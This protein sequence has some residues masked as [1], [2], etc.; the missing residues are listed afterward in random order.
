MSVVANETRATQSLPLGMPPARFLRDY[1]QKRPLLIRD[2]FPGGIDAISPNDLAGLACEEAALS[3]IISRD[4]KRE[5]WTLRNGPFRE[6]EFARL[7]KKDWT[8][9]VQDVD[10]WDADVAALLDR[11]RFIPSWRVDDVM[12]SYATDGGG[13][14]PHVDNYDVFLIQAR[15][16]RRWRI[17]A[18]P[19]ASKE[20]RD[21]SELKLLRE[22]A[23]THEWT[24]DSGDALYLPPGVPH[25]GVALGECMTCSVGMRAPAQAELLLD[26][27]EFLAEPLGDDLRYTDPD[28]AP[29][30]DANEIDDDALARLRVAM[31]QFT[32]VDQSILAH[33]FGCF[34]TRYRSAQIAAAR[35]R[36]ADDVRHRLPRAILLRNPFSRFAWRR[37][38]R[39][40][41]L[42][43]TGE[44][45]R[46]SL[47]FA[48]LVCAE[49]EIDGGKLAAVA[50]GADALQTLTA[51]INAG[52][53]Q[54]SRRR[55][56]AARR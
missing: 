43:V 44:A 51:L 37:V 17:S 38:G 55:D 56:R 18:D 34:I 12:V 53:L 9:L 36:S 50:A 27:A 30:H 40:A 32:H 7:G 21:D 22:F 33:W 48:R 10:K 25:D 46:C 11:F 14:G 23:P 35:A 20:F 31:P 16:Q 15:G 4:A 3:R 6:T 29:A 2:F 26:F 19:R 1:W 42:F 54:F 52:H 47:A 28:L 45:W 49:R 13:V 5:R 41:E 39:A 24:L 8:L